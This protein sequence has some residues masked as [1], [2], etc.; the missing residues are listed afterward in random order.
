MSGPRLRVVAAAHQDAAAAAHD[1][2]ASVFP[3]G[4]LRWFAALFLEWLL[5]MNYSPDTIKG[6]KTEFKRFFAWADERAITQ[7]NQV[8][9]AVLERYQKYLFHYHDPETNQGHSV[10][11][12]RHAAVMLRGFFSWLRKRGHLKSNPAAD[13]ELP[14]RSKRLPMSPPTVD[15]VEKIL[16]LPDVN[17]A[18]GLRDRAIMEV[19]YSTGIR[20][21]ELAAL[22]TEDIN[23][24]SGTLNVREGK[25][26]KD[27][28]VPIG[29]RAISWVE[30]WLRDGRPAVVAE[31]DHGR[32]FVQNRGAPLSPKVAC[33]IV[34]QYRDAAE[35]G[36]KGSCH[37]FRRAMA[38]GLL[39]NGV[40]RKLVQQML[41]HDDPRSTDLYAN[42]SIHKL[43]EAHATHHPAE[44]PEGPR[45]ASPGDEAGGADPVS[46]AV[47]PT[48]DADGEPRS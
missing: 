9:L 4:T 22:V 44:V 45:D 18:L 25:G 26:K 20:R 42:V 2:P 8:T 27:R 47:S 31:P 10:E 35:I 15:E 14:R 12:Q 30:Q 21:A 23:P 3:K 32:L 11:T 39:E 13:L 5:S 46:A 28:V 7:P 36:K 1:E 43:K 40:D 37:L 17:T 34:K 33:V 16:A 24:S 41:G 48:A 6:R 29:A 19:L 38:T